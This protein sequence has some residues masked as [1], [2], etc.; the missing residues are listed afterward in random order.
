[1]FFN[2]IF[3]IWVFGTS[4]CITFASA[5]EPFDRI[6]DMSIEMARRHS[7]YASLAKMHQAAI[8]NV[9]GSKNGASQSLFRDSQWAALH[10]IIDY[11]KFPGLISSF[12]Y[13]RAGPT[14]DEDLATRLAGLTGM[15][16]TWTEP[17]DQV[18]VNLCDARI[19][20]RQ[21]S[22]ASGWRLVASREHTDTIS[23]AIECQ[24]PAIGVKPASER[25]K[26]LLGELGAKKALLQ[27]KLR[28]EDCTDAQV[29]G[30]LRTLVSLSLELVEI[31][32]K[33]AL[34]YPEDFIDHTLMPLLEQPESGPVLSGILVLKLMP[35]VELLG[36]KT[37]GPKVLCP[38]FPY[39]EFLHEKTT[40]KQVRLVIAREQDTRLDANSNRRGDALSPLLQADPFAR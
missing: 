23:W 5:T 34:V 30:D 18:F 40:V 6:E 19:R 27:I 24:H 20:E 29:A 14:T 8:W 15:A 10:S 22:E 39:L 3:R 2:S 21:D 28:K 37:M 25:A 9:Q 1:M 38:R 4:L 26:T 16:P 17:R 35:S 33:E 11:L 36:A 13:P 7:V 32:G 31:F 12:E